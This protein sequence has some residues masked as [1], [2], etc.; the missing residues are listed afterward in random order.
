M[1]IY[2]AMAFSCNNYFEK[3]LLQVDRKEL[4]EKLK[5]IGMD[6]TSDFSTLTFNDPTFFGTTPLN[7]TDETVNVL[8]SAIGQGNCFTTVFSINCYTN[9]IANNGM[10]IEPHIISE[11]AADC[12]S[13]L[14]KVELMKKNICSKD[15]ANII[16][17][18]MQGVVDYGTA[19]R[20]LKGYNVIAKTGTAENV[21][22]EKNN[23]HISYNTS[24]ITLASL[25][26]KR[27]Y[28]VTV[29]I[30]KIPTGADSTDTQKIAQQ[31]CK[32][33]GVQ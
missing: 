33:L 6:S 20:Y 31:I 8:Y 16:K 1:N 5:D 21:K 27:P 4:K 13:N 14:E 18:A 30:D 19:S 12:N 3:L 25:N 28:S 2:S 24:W 26:K 15:I 29:A 32:V 10:L 7:S 11:K 9:V 17:E 22:I 23:K